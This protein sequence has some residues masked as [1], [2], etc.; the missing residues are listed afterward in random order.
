MCIRDSCHLGL[1]TS[2]RENLPLNVLEFLAL[3]KTVIAPRVGGIAEIAGEAGPVHLLDRNEPGA[4]ANMLET[5]LD[6]MSREA[7]KSHESPT[8]PDSLQ[9]FDSDAIVDE[10]IVFYR[11]AG[12]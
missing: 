5:L 12:A 6:T 8:A 1:C 2:D 4:Y 3:G 10:L 7:G 11:S 9:R